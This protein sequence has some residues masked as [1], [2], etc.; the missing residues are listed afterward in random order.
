MQRARTG[1]VGSADVYELF[2]RKRDENLVTDFE[3]FVPSKRLE[4]SPMRSQA[5]RS[6]DSGETQL[7]EIVIEKMKA[8]DVPKLFKWKKQW[9][10]REKRG[11]ASGGILMGMRESVNEVIRANMEE[12]EGTLSTIIKCGQMELDMWCTYI[13]GDMNEIM[14][15]IAKTTG[16]ANGDRKVIIGGDWNARTEIMGDPYIDELG[17]Q[18]VKESK[19]GKRGR[20]E[21][22]GVA[23]RE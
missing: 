11:R 7:L 16:G 9:A 2:K 17:D 8:F 19:D 15:W 5:G 18:V 6:E 23:K 13:N 20:A 21:Y 4:R 10:K 3:P 14:G 12:R 22:D 1:S